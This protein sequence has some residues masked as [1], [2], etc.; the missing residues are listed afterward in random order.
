MIYLDSNATT[1]IHPVVL[2]AMLPFFTDHCHN[3]SSGYR[4]GKYVKQAMETA[5][6]EVAALIG[7]D[8]GEIV[9]TGCGTESNNMALK[10]LARVVG[11][12]ESRVVTSVIEHSAVLRPC[13]A[14]EAVGFEVARCGVDELGRM[15]MDEFAE[16]VDEARPGFASVMWTNN[17]T[18]VV[19]PMGEACAVVKDAGW[20][21]H[22]DAIQAVGKVPLDVREVPVDFLSI[23]GHKFHAPKGVGALYVRE[24]VRF[25]PMMRGGGQE[26]GRR[27]G[28][29][30]VASI[31]GLGKAAAMM[32]EGLEKD[33]HVE[34]RRLRDHFEDRLVEEIQGVLL[35]GS[36][37]HRA[38][39][40]VH[41]SFESCEAAGLLI[42]L[43]EAGVQCSAGSACMTG[44]QQPSHVQKAMGFSDDRAKSSLRISLSILTTR[45]EVDQ[46]VE[47]VKKAVAKLRSVQGGGVGPV[48]I[49]GS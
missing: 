29:E 31:V 1:Q 23:S 38:G 37:E 49:Y 46:A 26:G 14:M 5:R 22:T 25:E 41:A 42:L 35:N 44:K 24:G 20:G 48:V 4:A 17:E 13:E 28:T 45:E 19:Q 27:S 47:A 32:R 30:N 36:R 6:E 43:D 39:N 8:P 11:R 34:M 3:P 2:E 18:G 7:A 15:R 21:F 16:L 33:G 9:F 40:I 10:S 12:K